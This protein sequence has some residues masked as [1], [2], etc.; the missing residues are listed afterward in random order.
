MTPRALLIGVLASGTVLAGVIIGV[1]AIG[2]AHP[3]ATIA[4]KA[5]VEAAPP[6]R[7]SR[8]TKA[9]PPAWRSSRRRIHHGLGDAGGGAFTHIVR[10]DGF[11][12]DRHEVTKRA[13][14]EIRRRDRLS[15]A[16]RARAG[17]PG[18]PGHAQELMAP[19]SVVFVQ[20]TGRAARRP[21]RA[22]VA[23]RGRRELAQPDGSG[24]HD[25][26]TSTASGG[27]HRP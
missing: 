14:P 12:I 4:A 27:A 8:P 11:W 17:S 10:V 16:G 20:P 6:M 7:A 3:K 15:H 21:D 24:Q 25:R 23:V 13:V 22:M 5:A 9:T 19:G 1:L 2:I 26:G 18:A